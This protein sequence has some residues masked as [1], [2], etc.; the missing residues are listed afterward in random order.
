VPGFEKTAALGADPA[1]TVVLAA[2]QSTVLATT[3]PI[4]PSGALFETRSSGWR[5]RGGLA[6]ALV[7]SAAMSG[8]LLLLVDKLREPTLRAPVLVALRESTAR[9]RIRQ[10]LPHTPVEVA[11]AYSIRVAAGQVIRQAPQPG[12]HVTPEAGIRL[13]VSKGTPF[14]HVPLVA[15]GALPDDARAL[16]VH[17]GFTVRY[18]YT[19]S[20][21]IRKGTVIDLQPK[22]GTRLRRPTSVKILIASGYPRAVV[23]N[24]QTA[25]LAA[26]Q[27]HLVAKHLQYRVVYRVQHGV[28]T[29]RVIG[30]I[31]AAGATVYRGTRVRLTVTRTLRWVK[32]L[33]QTGVDHYE[34]DPFTVPAR[35]RIRYRL[36]AG[37]FGVA[38]AQFSWAHD[39]AFFRDGGFVSTTAHELQ[40]HAVSDG[41]GTY[42][43]A[44]DPY[45]G[46]GWYV[47]VDALG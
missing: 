23:P 2:E 10:L 8:G 43:L 38:V 22:A 42:R 30:Q 31:P 47:E 26:A 15:A 9:V 28:P 32:I 7:A 36:D 34:S 6:M 29:D 24:V 37:P 1:T 13:L 14:A 20:W 46:S 5:R 33:A 19:P 11:R 17:T 40:T 41:A 18:R 45:A 35:W 4:S 39:G 12:A 27:A 25:D 44:V 3:V 21:R 16:L